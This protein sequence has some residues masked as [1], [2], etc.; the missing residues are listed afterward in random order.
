MMRTPTIAY[1]GGKA[2]LAKHIV[3]FLP[4]EGG[5][6][7]EPFCGRGNLYWAAASAPLNYE[8]WRLND[9]ATI[10]FFRAISQF[11]HTIQVPEISRMEYDRQREA[12][13]AGDP[14]AA[15]LEP[16]LTFGGAGYLSSG[17]RGQRRGGVS[18]L[19]Y[20][21]ALRECHRLMHHT[22]PQLTTLDWRGMGLSGLG[23]DD[24]VVLDPPYPD[25]DPGP[26]AETSL[27]YCEL[28]DAL[29]SA[30]FRW[31]LCGYIHP[32]LQ[33]LG[34]PFW[35]K[36]I[37]FLRFPSGRGRKHEEE[38][39]TECLWR[40]S[41]GSPAFKHYALPLALR[42]RL[43]TQDA[44]ATLPFIVLDETIQTALE[45]A[46]K[47]WKALVPYLL[48]MH[49]RLSA[50]GRRTDLRRGAPS[51]LTWTE[52]VDSKRSK[53]GRS[54]RTIQSMLRGRTEASKARQLRLAQPRT[55]LTAKQESPMPGTALA[56]ASEMAR[57]VLEMR[58]SYRTNQATRRRVE[59]LAKR[60]LQIAGKYEIRML[61]SRPPMPNALRRNMQQ[62]AI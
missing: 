13:K 58:R 31:F 29:L 48:E 37:R 51:G 11:G 26:Y 22:K 2:R 8:E 30:K 4:K 36:E 3:S 12:S 25:T 53:L 19:V 27:D 56:V 5:T 23:P 35:A 9:I 54:L 61:R 49:R 60:F 1:P 20:Q 10:P 16:F 50:P 6:Y 40:N 46:A 44:A 14:T 43:R 45:K 62:P 52:W 57:L 47:D 59:L 38:Q 24:T 32:A 39:R 55:D 18:P 41:T 15:L 21:N 28:V 7:V 42:S 17:F 34:R 33:R